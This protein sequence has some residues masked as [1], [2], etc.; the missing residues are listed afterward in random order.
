[1][2][3]LQ[4]NFGTSGGERTDNLQ[5]LILDWVAVGPVVTDIYDRLLTRFRLNR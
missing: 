1:V 5:A 2:S 3:Q 4:Q